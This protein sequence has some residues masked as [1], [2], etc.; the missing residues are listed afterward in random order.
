[1]STRRWVFSRHEGL[2]VM[3]ELSVSKGLSV[4]KQLGVLTDSV[5]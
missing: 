3:K 4:L 5:R 2:G 1:M